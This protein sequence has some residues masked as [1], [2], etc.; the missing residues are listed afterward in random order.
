MK[1]RIR[2]I[3]IVIL[4][5]GM[6]CPFY[7]ICQMLPAYKK[8]F[9]WLFRTDVSHII[10][11]FIFYGVLGWLVLSV[12]SDRKSPI[13]WFI[14]ILGFLSIA[15]AQEVMQLLTGQGPAGLD[16]IFDTLV[17]LSGALIGISIFKWKWGRGKRGIKKF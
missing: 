9:D 14:F 11:R 15:V 12:F 2:I 13:P 8:V 16:D 3:V 7:L 4:I 5:I 1:R 17:D 10:M 6:L